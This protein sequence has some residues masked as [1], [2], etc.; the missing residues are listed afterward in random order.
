MEPHE[1]YIGKAF[2]VLE[3]R[4]VV[5]GPALHFFEDSLQRKLFRFFLSFFDIIN[6]VTSGRAT[7]P[8]GNSLIPTILLFQVVV[9]LFIIKIFFSC[10]RRL[11]EESLEH[12]NGVEL[13]KPFFQDNSLFLR[14]KVPRLDGTSIDKDGV[15]Y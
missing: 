7:S 11:S 12:I 9:N 5:R 14:S 3:N 2:I 4:H 6:E 1:S 8:Y 13:F 10:N 15:G